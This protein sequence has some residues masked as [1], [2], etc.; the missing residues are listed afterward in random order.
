MRRHSNRFQIQTDAKPFTDFL[1]ERH[2]MNAA[3]L[4][5]TL[6]REIGHE[7]SD[8]LVREMENG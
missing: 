5:V 1:A 3:D 7:K 2:V 6:F 8:G 4:N